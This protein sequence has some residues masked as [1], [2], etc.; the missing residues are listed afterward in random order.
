MIFFQKTIH[1]LLLN[2]LTGL[3]VTSFLGK[4]GLSTKSLS[5]FLM[6]SLL[7][8]SC[9]AQ[10]APEQLFVSKKNPHLIA[11]TN[12]KPV[13][14]NSFT[15][16]MLLRNGSRKDVEDLLSGL[17]Q[18]KLNAI[19]M[20][21]LD[22]SVND[23]GKN[24][25]GDNAFQLNKDELPDPLNP[26]VTPGN[27]PE[28]PEEYDFWDHLD[29]VIHTANEKGMYV[30][31]HP[32]WGDWFTGSYNGKPDKYIVF[33]EENAY[34]YGLWIGERYRN[35]KNVI[36]MVGGDRSAVYGKLDYKN[37]F[38][39]LA[40][41][42]TDGVMGN[43]K[44][45][46]EKSV[47]NSPLISYHPRKWALNSSEWFHHEQWLSFNSIQDT[48]YDQVVSVPN[49]Y[50]LKT[51]KPTW[52]CE[53]RYEGAI[54]DWGVRYQAWQTVLSGGFGHTYGSDAWKFPKDNWRQYL[55]LPGLA[56][57]GYMYH[58][59]REIWTDKQF[60]NRM[61]D[62]GL[63]IGDQGTTVGDGNT[64]ED[65]DGGGAAGSKVN[66][67]SDR[68]TA[69]R[70]NDGSWAMVYT[71]AGKNIHLD[72]TRLNGKLNA[73]WYNPATGKW[74]VAGKELEKMQP[75]QKKIETGKGDLVFDAPGD[76][77]KENDWVLILKR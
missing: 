23:I 10:H 69:M 3:P 6:F 52:L 39:A 19:S 30:V 15:V 40:K 9:F 42:I 70:G 51:V 59:V 22:L 32:A 74:W 4:K 48:P 8:M 75:F 58:A 29:F 24:Y 66:G 7:A 43:S 13:F 5:L 71:A 56:Q 41:G 1:S 76:P 33:N 65:G 61:P 54:T 47:D 46:S 36:W 35:S 53:G 2:A 26:V 77:R 34:K 67:S 14:L 64:R 49:D 60:L 62:Q 37:V 16:W 72:L 28:S 73:Y 27:N 11:T 20:I 38:A 31:L 17:K 68:I 18:K 45:R 55:E 50:E 12:E 21:A 57:M 25:Y 44:K 63:I